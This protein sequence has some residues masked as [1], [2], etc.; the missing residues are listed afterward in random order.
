[1]VV[2]RVKFFGDV[3]GFAPVPTTM[4]ELN[5]GA[6]VIDLL[7]ELADLYG[8]RFQEGVLSQSS[9]LYGVKGHVQLFMN[10]ESVERRNFPTTKI[11]AE[12]AAAEATLFVVSATTGG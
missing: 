11:V 3:K 6:S 8:K 7:K 2:V 9:E 10:G 12:G 5:D 1:M 4:V